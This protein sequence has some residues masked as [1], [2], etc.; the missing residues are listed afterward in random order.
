VVV[1]SK[2]THTVSSADLSLNC[3]SYVFVLSGGGLS[4]TSSDGIGKSEPLASV[5]VSYGFG[6]HSVLTTCHWPLL[7]AQS[8]AT[9]RAL[10]E[11]NPLASPSISSPSTTEITTPESHNDDT[12]WSAYPYWSR[13]VPR[14]VIV[15]SNH[16]NL[17]NVTLPTVPT[18]NDTNPSSNTNSSPSINDDGEDDDTVVNDSWS[19]IGE[20]IRQCNQQCSNVIASNI[21]VECLCPCMQRLLA[22]AYIQ[23]APRLKCPSSL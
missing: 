14:A 23:W 17:A 3:S 20:P 6:F 16:N 7:R 18:N 15:V 4:L 21:Y 9:L 8:C 13:Y 12:D 1:A 22:A 19:V 11:S 2:Y 10:P 5:G